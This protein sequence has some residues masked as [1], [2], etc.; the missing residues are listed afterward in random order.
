MAIKLDLIEKYLYSLDLKYEKINEETINLSVSNNNDKVL[1]FIILH[2]DGE[3]L[4][5]RT[6]KHLDDLLAEASEEKRV[7]LLKWM[8]ENNYK[9]KFGT[10]EYNPENHQHHI[11]IEHIIAD[12]SLIEKQFT[13]I[14]NIICSSINHIPEMKKILGVAGGLSEKEKKRQELLAQLQELDESSI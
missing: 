5:V 12:G 2:D 11:T 10:W 14:F 8:L 13:R 1:I 3:Y 9:T 7:D 4:E 6:F